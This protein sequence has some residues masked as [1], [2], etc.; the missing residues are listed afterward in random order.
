MRIGPRALAL[1]RALRGRSRSGKHVRVNSTIDGARDTAGAQR[2]AG[3]RMATA[4]VL[5]LALPAL[6]WFGAAGFVARGLRYPQ[7]LDSGVGDVAG[8]HI[9]TLT[10]KP[11]AVLRAAIG[12]EPEDF[13]AGV[14]QDN[15]VRAGWPV[16]VRGW[17]L[18]APGTRAIVLIPPTGGSLESMVP[19]LSMLHGAGYTVAA[20]ESAGNPHLGTDWGWSERLAARA[21]SA[22]LRADGFKAVGALGVSEGGAAAIFAQAESRSFD[23]IAAD[24]AYA[25]LDTMFRRNPSIAGL[26]P[27]FS[28]TVFLLAREI[29]FGIPFDAIAPARAAAAFNN[30]PLLVIQNGADPVTPIKDGE[31]IRA[32]AGRGAEIWIARV[33]GHA[34]AILEAPDDYR[35][36]VTE[37]FARAMR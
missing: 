6:L 17:L 25:N 7:F 13:D 2:R 21:A 28:A 3:R 5:M 9:P 22:K 18:R 27:A 24:S 16:Y 12:V 23:A 11:V 34:N 35:A 1:K 20:L 32:A 33:A 30:C 31:A 29:W 4:M 36:R 14:V 19:Y 10:G 26:N 8:P 37:F 15:S